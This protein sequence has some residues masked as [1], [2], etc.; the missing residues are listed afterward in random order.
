[1]NISNSM[2]PSM[3]QMR[4]PQQQ[5]PMTEDQK[6]AVKSILSE[7]DASNLTEEDFHEINQQFKE[8]GVR[9]SGDLKETI[10]GEGFDFS[11][12]LENGRP[13]GGGQIPPPPPPQNTQASEY[14]EQLSELLT[15]YES[16]EADQ[17]D[18]ISFIESIKANNFD[19]L[20]NIVNQKA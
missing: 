17:E 16:G 13:Q 1:M 4:P 9:P 11:S 19:S 14:S 7:Y 10:E 6:T 3:M 15:A 20:G 12:Y 18:F 2:D 5:N 8:L